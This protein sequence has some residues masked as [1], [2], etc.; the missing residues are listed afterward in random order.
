MLPCEKEETGI[1][2]V[3]P[4]DVFQSNRAQE[5]FLIKAW[6]ETRDGN[7]LARLI[8][9]YKPLFGNQIK[10]ILAGRAISKEHR[11]DLQQECRL[12]FITAVESYDPNRNASLA[13]HAQTR[14]R[15][16]LLQYS[17][18]FRSS[19]RIGRGSDERKAYYAAQRMR[20]QKAGSGDGYIDEKEIEQ[21]SKSTGASVKATRRAV[22]ST[23]TSQTSLDE[24]HDALTQADHGEKYIDSS[25]RAQAMEEVRDF[26]KGISE[27]NRE[28][29]TRSFLSDDDP[30]NVQLSEDFDVSPERIGQ[31]KRD[32]LKKLQ[33]H[34]AEAGLDAED[35]L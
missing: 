14:I 8:D 12:A 23:Q 9:N 7:A 28:I 4:G 22:E 15:N 5:P 34:L 3:Q 10:M 24:E 30:S 32:V 17:L 26:L 2:Q 31:I 18:D 33:E 29:I 19:Y 13:T 27:R 25:A 35:I 1:A 16:A 21:I 6:R 20:A 11:D